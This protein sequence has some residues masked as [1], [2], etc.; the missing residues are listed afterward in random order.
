M[1]SSLHPTWLEL[2]S[3]T[4]RVSHEVYL[5]RNLFARAQVLTFVQLLKEKFQYS[6]WEDLSFIYLFFSF[7]QGTPSLCFQRPLPLEAEHFWACISRR[8]W[9]RFKKKK[10]FLRS[11]KL[12][13]L[14]RFG[15]MASQ[16]K[17]QRNCRFSLHKYLRKFHLENSFEGWGNLFWGWGRNSQ[18]DPLLFLK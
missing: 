10:F 1:L 2:Q 17:F 8:C 13:R 6:Q 18:D 3:A 14:T 9:D 15:E 12:S 7:E 11:F 4:K 16:E 5:C